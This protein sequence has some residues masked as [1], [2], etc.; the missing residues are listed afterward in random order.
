MMSAKKVSVRVA[1]LVVVLFAVVA[2]IGA[3]PANQT[4]SEFYMTY[5]A[6]FAKAKA[7]EQ[8]LPLMSAEMKAQV[9][10]TPAAER[11][12]MFEF[13]QQMSNAMTNV[14]VIKET[15]TDT[16][17]TLT[18]EALDGKDKMSGQIQ[19]VKEGAAWKMGK[20]SWSSKS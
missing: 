3:Q 20:E 1:F 16:G 17:A 5:R 6:A 13:V 10:K 15:K 2:A 12:K 19:V 14:K 11:P 7:I 4:A 9:E 8:M 18:V